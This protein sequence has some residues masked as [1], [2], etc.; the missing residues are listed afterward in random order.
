MIPIPIHIDK[1]TYAE[2]DES[3]HVDEIRVATWETDEEDSEYSENEEGKNGN[4]S[5]LK[6]ENDLFDLVAGVDR[7]FPPGSDPS[8]SDTSETTESDSDCDPDDEDRESAIFMMSTLYVFCKRLN[9]NSKSVVYQ[10]IDRLT[11]E[12]VVVK[13]TSAS[14]H[15]Y[16]SDPM[17][18]K[19]YSKLMGDSTL[20][21][22]TFKSFY[23][24]SGFDVVVVSYHTD[25][26][27]IESVT[28]ESLQRV[29]AQQLA[30]TIQ[31]L[32]SNNI[33][34]RDLKL[35]NIMWDNC[36]KQ[37][38]LIDFDIAT[39]GS[40]RRD[41]T[42][43]SYTSGYECPD[44]FTEDST[45]YGKEIDVWGIG[46]IL[47]CITNGID[48][49]TITKQMVKAWSTST[50]VRGMHEPVTDLIVRCLDPNPLTR[51]TIP[52]ILV[53]PFLISP[54]VH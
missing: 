9:C 50:G 27:V 17:E 14:S 46:V 35:S 39:F 25:D 41:H 30:R 10:A 3:D 52:E 36:T 4:A 13:F 19:I 2:V 53:H 6:D 24:I 51:I 21:I 54:D 16:N 29:F 11:R 23:R 1:F 33:I 38:I 49:M 26:D 47:L 20:Q 48:E 32:H 12:T 18:V 43:I 40:N 45:G 15:P 42:E 7:L 22:P 31:V 44:M 8:G 28:S 5:E 37:L 34:Y